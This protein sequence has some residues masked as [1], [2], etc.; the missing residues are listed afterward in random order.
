MRQLKPQAGLTLIELMVGLTIM[1]LLAM[2]AAPFLGDYLANSRLRESGHTLY[3][4]AL[5]AQSEA[6]KRNGTVRLSTN[7]STVQVIDRA[8]ATPVVLRERSLPSGITAATSTIDFGA[9]GLT[10]PFGT[11]GSINVT[12]AGVTC[13]T[14]YRC[15]GLRVDAGGAVRLC[16]DT[17]VTGC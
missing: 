15:P 11:T 14:N 6:I 12:L 13:S 4:E 5:A 3:S 16:T 8:P 10:V 2:S 7:G 17:T 1:A 9:D